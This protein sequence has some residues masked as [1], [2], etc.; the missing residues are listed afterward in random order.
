MIGETDVARLGDIIQKIGDYDVE[1]MNDL[2]EALER[3]RSG[4]SVRV[5]FLRDGAAQS[6]EVEL[7]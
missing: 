3:F 1:N 6:A 5:Q 2:L 4:D 7:Q